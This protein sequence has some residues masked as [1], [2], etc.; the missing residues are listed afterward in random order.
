MI[1]A[2]GEAGLLHRDAL[3]VSGRTIWEDVAEA[4]NYNA[5]V[6]RPL[7]KALTGDGGSALKLETWL[8]F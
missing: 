2:L 5:D 6:I 4:E 1:K 3:T 7:D 8:T